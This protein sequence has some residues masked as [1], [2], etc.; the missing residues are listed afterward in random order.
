[1]R[2]VRASI[3]VLTVGAAILG[4]SCFGL[5]VAEWMDFEDDAF[6]AEWLPRFSLSAAALGYFLA[7]E[8]IPKPY[9]RTVGFAVPLLILFPF[10]VG[11]IWFVDYAHDMTAA[12]IPE[13]LER[14]L[15]FA[16]LFMYLAAASEWAFLIYAARRRRGLSD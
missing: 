14:S 4:L 15:S 12:Q 6:L 1:M 13:W 16:I 3:R 9:R 11:T 5:V 7:S 2:F 10:A 8:R